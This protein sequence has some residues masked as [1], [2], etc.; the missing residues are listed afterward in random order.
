MSVNA[1]R[2]DAPT[3]DELGPDRPLIDLSSRQF[4][5]L[6]GVLSGIRRDHSSIYGLRMWA[7]LDGAVHLCSPDWSGES[8]IWRNGSVA[9][10]ADDEV[11]K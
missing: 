11:G 3:R 6:P 4:E 10:Y 7:D 9:E 2:A 1:Q 8:V 5:A